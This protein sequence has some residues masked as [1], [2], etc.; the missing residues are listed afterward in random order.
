[1]PPPPQ[2]SLATHIGTPLD[3]K[4][5]ALFREIKFVFAL[6]QCFD[7]I[8]TTF[9]L[10]EIR[11]APPAR[12]IWFFSELLFEENNSTSLNVSLKKAIFLNKIC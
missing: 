7:F 2:M 3:K 11:M 1:M 10:I 8:P 6:I 9:L 5:V 4:T 12:R